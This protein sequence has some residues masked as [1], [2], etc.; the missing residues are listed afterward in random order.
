MDEVGRWKISWA[1]VDD[2]PETSQRSTCNKPWLIPGYIQHHH[3]LTD[4]AGV[5]GNK[6]E[7][8]QCNETHES[9]LGSFSDNFYNSN[10][11][12]CN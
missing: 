10:G 7:I 12:D 4:N 5:I 11:K 6:R 9:L 3:Y 8:F 2:K 1:V